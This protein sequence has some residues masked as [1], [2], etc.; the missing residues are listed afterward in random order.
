MNESVETDLDPAA[1][2][3]FE[4]RIG[5]DAA[6]RRFDQALAEA[7]PQ[8]SRARLAG[9]IKDGR[10]TLNGEVRRPKDSVH[11]GDAVVLH[12]EREIQISDEP[13]DIALDILF[14][15]RDVLVLNKPAGLVVHPGAGNARGTLV[16]ALLHHDP[17]L[18]E[19]PRA[20]I[21]HRLDKDTSGAM[22]VAKT[23]QAHAALVA[24]LSERE[25]NRR[26]LALVN[27]TLIAGGRIDAPI[28]RH[29]RDR[30]RMGV[31]EGGRDAIT[32]YRVVERFRAHT[33]LS[34]QLETGRTHQIR[35]HLAHIRHG[36]VGDPLYGPGLKLPKGAPPAL[37]EC[38]RGFKRQALHA[39]EL[40][41]EH[42]RTKK[43]VAFSAV[44]P[45]DMEE[46]IAFLRRASPPESA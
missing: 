41:F 4:F 10:A 22:V 26:Y 34:C 29:P 9:W 36:I 7:L 37:I 23:L 32:H 39:A 25:V 45:E 30:I 35:V 46:L 1:V 18:R 13:E 8:F 24:Q 43:P 6:G 2:E 21:V 17:T 14:E 5:A 15:D 11:A 27:G 31:V 19:L 33:L 38:L 20:G 42:P 28:D 44:M 12:A 3:H 16:N 40:A